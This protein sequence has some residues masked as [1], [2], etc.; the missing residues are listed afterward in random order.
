MNFNLLI[1]IIIGIIAVWFILGME[2]GE[3]DSAG[4][5]KRLSEIK[6]RTKGITNAEQTAKKNIASIL[7]EDTEYKISLLGNILKNI[8]IT[9][10]IKKMLKIAGIRIT[11]D[12]FLLISIGCGIPFFLPVFI[13]SPAK[14]ALFIPI[15]VI[16]IFIPF[17]IVKSKNKKRLHMFTQQFPEAL[18]LMCSSLRAGHS[19]VASFQMIVQEMPD[20]ISQIFKVVVD[21]V[22]LGRDTRT[23]L[24]NMVEY[25]PDSM[26]LRFF[27]TA[28]LIQREI[29]GNLTEILDSLSFTIR[30]RFRLL[31]QIATQTAQA[32]L[33]GIVLGLAPI[34]IALILLVLN[35]AYLEALYKTLMGIIALG[36]A[37]VLELIGFFVI[38]KI[39]QIRV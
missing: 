24:E 12:I 11:V 29:G 34:I 3:N 32:K 6:N 30:E 14:A 35:P 2:D 10:K 17:V 9:D 21:D 22:A 36:V 25:M 23:A 27:V 8:K 15:G 4:I 39:T 31:G 26:D 13:V 7:L 20:P 28:V 33:S 19:L 5:D 1:I 16:F 37:I 38:M 18:G